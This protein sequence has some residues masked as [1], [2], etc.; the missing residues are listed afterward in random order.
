MAG[1]RVT[2]ARWPGA[3]N[4]HDLGG[5]PL[6]AGGTTVCGR[7][8]RSAAAEHL[9]DEGWTAA[10]ECGVRTVI[11]LRNAPLETRRGP[12]HPS[13]AAESYEGLTFVSAP[14]DAPENPDFLRVCGPWLDR[15]RSW[16]GNAETAPANIVRVMR[17]VAGHGEGVLVHCSA[18]RDRT[19]MIC[20]MLLDLAGATPRAIAEDYADGWRGA[21]EL[22]GPEWVYHPAH[23]VWQ[24]HDRVP[25]PEEETERL[26]D[27]R[28]GELRDWS[29]SFDTGAFLVANGL[30]PAE[31]DAL[32]GLL[33]P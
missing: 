21:A 23:R 19:G 1:A 10:R 14:V 22:S 2:G 5:R 13:V 27:E 8:F 32:T 24:R 26:L 17:A 15:P 31:L 3:R 12:H 9:T 33:R 16:T 30:S 7:V 6:Q 11:D 20:A 18:G 29:G 25:V 4:L 28:L